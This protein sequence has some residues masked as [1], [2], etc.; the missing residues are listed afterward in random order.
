V[1]AA[2]V[3]AAAGAAWPPGLALASIGTDGEDGPTD[4]AGAVADA[5]V[6][7]LAASAPAAA[8]EALDRCDAHPFLDRIGG[9][10][11]SG[12]TGTNVADL[13]IVLARR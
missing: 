2:L 6:W 7:A 5:A 11:R 4:A 12:P 3:A 1:L 10:V 9:L 13:R 8:R